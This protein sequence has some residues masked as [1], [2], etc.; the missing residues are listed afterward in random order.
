MTRRSLTAILLVICF[1]CSL[2]ALFFPQKVRSAAA[3]IVISEVQ[4]GGTNANDEF[5]ELYNPT[6]VTIDLSGFRLVRKNAT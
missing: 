2:N 1:F 3:H 6:S 5:V 4:V